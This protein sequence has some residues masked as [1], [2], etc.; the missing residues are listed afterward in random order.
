MTNTE[1]SVIFFEKYNLGSF[2]STHRDEH[3]ASIISPLACLYK[4][5]WPKNEPSN[6]PIFFPLTVGGAYDTL[7]DAQ[8]K[9]DI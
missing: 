9:T 5:L 7:K 2:C 8:D 1:F 4:K 3:Y 6:F